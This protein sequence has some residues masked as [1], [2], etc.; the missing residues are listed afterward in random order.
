[1]NSTD[2]LKTLKNWALGIVGF[3]TTISAV[4]VQILHFPVEPTLLCVL[5]F[6]GVMLLVVYLISKSEQR[7]KKML[8][9]HTEESV[10]ITKDF[11]ERLDSIDDV[12]LDIQRSTLRTEICNEMARHPDN[13]D[14][15]LKMAEKYFGERENGGLSANWYMS[16]KFLD[17]A[18]KE[19]VKLPPSIQITQK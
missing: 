1:M 16:S 6:A 14:S 7:Q 15:I 10:Q 5:G 11:D 8:Q 3:S 4:L 17:W 19:G 2:D 12:L 13:H 18:E 9:A